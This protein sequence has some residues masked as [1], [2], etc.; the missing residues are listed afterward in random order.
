MCGANAAKCSV[1]RERLRPHRTVCR[2][3]QSIFDIPNTSV[4]KTYSN[5]RKTFELFFRTL[6]YRTERAF[7]LRGQ[8]GKLQ[9]WV[10]EAEYYA[11]KLASVN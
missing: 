2:N 9:N 1:P 3:E 10:F 6:P 5:R 8:P 11:S 7:H 4:E